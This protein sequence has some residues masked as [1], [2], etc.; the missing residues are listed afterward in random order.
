MG[1]LVLAL[2]GAAATGVILVWVFVRREANLSQLQ[3][4]F[5]SKVSHEL[6]T[7]LTSIRLFTETLALAPGDAGAQKTVHRRRSSARARACRSSSIACSTGGAWRAGGAST[8]CRDTDVRRIVDE[9]R[10]R[11]R[12]VRERRGT[13]SSTC[14]AAAGSAARH[15]PIAAR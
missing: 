8:T 10:R 15:V 13:S 1:I 11:L 12:A 4:D 6:R 7:P 9:A 2:S 5:V 14:R 3:T